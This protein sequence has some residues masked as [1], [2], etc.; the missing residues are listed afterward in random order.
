MSLETR[1][2]MSIYSYLSIDTVQCIPSVV[3]FV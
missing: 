1:S 2:Y 3:Y